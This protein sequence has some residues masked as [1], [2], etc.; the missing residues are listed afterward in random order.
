MAD[1][2]SNPP[3][4]VDGP[5]L[6]QALQ[7]Q[8]GLKLESDRG[9]VEIMIIDQVE[10]PSEFAQSRVTT[11]AARRSATEADVGLPIYP[12]ATPDREG[13]PT[14]F[15]GPVAFNDSA[16][17]VIDVPVG[18]AHSR[19]VVIKLRTSDDPDR[20]AAFYKKA[21]AMYGTVLDCSDPANIPNVGPDEATCA[22]GLGGKPPILQP[23]ELLFRSGTQ[24]K[25]H[26]VGIQT[27]AGFTTFQLVYFEFSRER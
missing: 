6:F 21:L 5:S 26:L 15:P 24:N 8:L 22:A 2:G 1:L 27:R 25:E 11:P 7:E 17:A 18:R 12:G 23:G 19:T 4:P 3:P 10:K 14:H 16:S 20:V 9:L 13:D